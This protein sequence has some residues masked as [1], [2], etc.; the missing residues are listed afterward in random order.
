VPVCDPQAQP[1]PPFRVKPTWSKLLYEIRHRAKPVSP[2][3]RPTR[4]SSV[5]W[6]CSCVTFL[7]PGRTTSAK[8][9]RSSYHFRRK[10]NWNLSV[11]PTIVQTVENKYQ[12][13]QYKQ[14]NK[15]N[16]LRGSTNMPTFMGRDGDFTRFDE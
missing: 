5:M 12:K 16:D 13:S 10:F 15:Y 4:I 3:K 7:S 6:I 1:D 9:L 8:F 11:I 14:H 2:Y